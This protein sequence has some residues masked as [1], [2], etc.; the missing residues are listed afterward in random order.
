MWYRNEKFC[1][2]FSHELFI[3]YLCQKV[4]IPSKATY[5]NQTNKTNYVSKTNQQDIGAEFTLC[6]SVSVTTCAS[7]HRWSRSC[8]WNISNWN[9]ELIQVRR[10]DA[11]LL[12]LY[13][14]Y[15]HTF[16]R[17]TACPFQAGTICGTLSCRDIHIDLQRQHRSTDSLVVYVMKVSYENK[18]CTE[19]TET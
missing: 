15:A 6:T 3:I 5:R 13:Y 11:Y 7:Q 4:A 2:C 17:I 9:T 8:K 10:H 18:P 16:S 14:C 19:R 12:I 1:L